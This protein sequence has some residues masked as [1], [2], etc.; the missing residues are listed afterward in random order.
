METLEAAF[1]LFDGLLP[2]LTA[3]KAPVVW[4]V[5]NAGQIDPDFYIA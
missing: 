5:D 1:E 2:L 3:S 4:S